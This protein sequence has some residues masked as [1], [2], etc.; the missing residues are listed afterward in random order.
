MLKNAISSSHLKEGVVLSI[1]Y[2]CAV[3]RGQNLVL[4]AY[5]FY[6]DSAQLTPPGA[7]QRSSKADLAFNSEVMFSL[8]FCYQGQLQVHTQ[9]R[10]LAKRTTSSKPLT[11]V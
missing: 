1:S 5:Q 3:Q 11:T 10:A 2:A 4:G 8:L 7:R 6:R 9:E